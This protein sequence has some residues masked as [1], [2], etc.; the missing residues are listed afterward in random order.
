LSSL[1]EIQ[2]FHAIPKSAKTPAVSNQNFYIRSTN[3]IHA[4]LAYIKK[5]F[6]LEVKTVFNAC[7]TNMI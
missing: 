7:A 1:V 4:E 3:I 5:E 2:P 6:T